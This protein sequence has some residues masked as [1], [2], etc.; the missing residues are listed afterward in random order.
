ME[1]QDKY[2]ELEDIEDT[3]RALIDRI[4]DKDYIEQLRTAG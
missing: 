1:L 3:A 2:D 4:T